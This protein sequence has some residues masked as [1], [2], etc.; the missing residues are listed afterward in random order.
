MEDNGPGD[1][2]RNDENMDLVGRLQS[3][4]HRMVDT[5]CRYRELNMSVD[6]IRYITVPVRFYK[7][8]PV[9]YDSPHPA[10]GFAGW[11]TRALK[12]PLDQ[13]A[14]VC[15]HICNMGM[16]ERL[17][18][19]PD[20]PYQGLLQT[21]EQVPRWRQTII[22]HIVPLLAA[23]RK[24]E[25]AVC[26]V[27]SVENYAS[28]YSQYHKVKNLAGDEPARPAGAVNSDWWDEHVADAFG[29]QYAP[30]S[31]ASLENADFPLQARPEG[32]EPVVVTAHQLNAVLRARGIWNLI[33]VGFAL[34]FCIWLSHC[35]MVDMRRFK[36][37]CSVV[38]QCT[39]VVERKESTGER[40]HF[41]E[42]LWK[43][44]INFGYILDEQPLREVLQEASR[45]RS[46]PE[47]GLG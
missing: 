38:R 10:S 18:W 27:A 45:R 8:Y 44:A 28:R 14:L 40:S 23:A 33:Y 13:S 24:A 15:M 6:K 5:S 34:N 42:S 11:S 2:I 47:A 3:C 29:P 35:G 46:T 20:A 19:G 7:H 9:D 32:D 36:Y 17:P 31:E 4:R 25:M 22:E 30:D 26:H 12:I 1:G 16:D 41:Y 37:R 21:T 39:T 43:T